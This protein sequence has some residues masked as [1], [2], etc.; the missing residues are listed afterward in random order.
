MAT[1][2]GARG[3][4]ALSRAMRTRRNAVLRGGG[5]PLDGPVMSLRW[6]ARMRELSGVKTPTEP[7]TAPLPIE[8][9]IDFSSDLS[10]PYDINLVE[11]VSGYQ[12]VGAFV[13]FFGSFYILHLY[14]K[15]TAMPRYLDPQF[16]FR[17]TPYDYENSSS[18]Y[19]DL[20][21]AGMEDRVRKA[22]GLVGLTPEQSMLRKRLMSQ[23]NLS[24]E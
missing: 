21:K 18:V 1:A 19:G 14:S 2:S 22:E 3:L 8:H 20:W 7:P 9:E 13:L 15:H 24:K 23:P 6:S 12:V 5:G 4:A 10:S 16:T 11:T 17:E